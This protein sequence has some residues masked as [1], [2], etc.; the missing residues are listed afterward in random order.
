MEWQRQRQYYSNVGI[1]QGLRAVYYING[2]F[3]ILPKIRLSLHHNLPV[4]ALT[5]KQVMTT[6]AA[7]V[8][9]QPIDPDSLMTMKIII[10]DHPNNR[11]QPL[12]FCPRS[13][14]NWNSNKIARLVDRLAYRFDLT[15][16]RA[17]VFIRQDG[18]GS[19][20]SMRKAPDSFI[21]YEFFLL[22]ILYL[23]VYETIRN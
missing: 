22:Y 12:R 15:W 7:R 3:T 17:I 16:I 9:M 6:T 21:H 18:T 23:F 8:A 4:S 20:Q 2:V 14:T 19:H 10:R 11:H 1:I 13:C 5:L